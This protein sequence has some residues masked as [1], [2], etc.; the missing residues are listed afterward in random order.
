M[1]RVTIDYQY[2]LQDFFRAH[3]N[4]SFAQ[5]EIVNIS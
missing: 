5:R 1:K 4:N 2:Q 3:M